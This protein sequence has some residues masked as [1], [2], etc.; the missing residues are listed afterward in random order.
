MDGC[1]TGALVVVLTAGV[2]AWF[3]LKGL[4]G[5]GAPLSTVFSLCLALSFR[6]CVCV[7]VGESERDS[8][9]VNAC[10]TVCIAMCVIFEAVSLLLFHCFSV[11]LCLCA[12]EMIELN[13]ALTPSVTPHLIPS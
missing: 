8:I 10:Q 4:Q 6:V 13:A 5:G 2:Q 12:S 1:S 11:S 3:G 9:T 7:W